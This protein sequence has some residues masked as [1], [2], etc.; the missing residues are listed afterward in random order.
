MELPFVSVIVL[1]FNGAHFLPTCLNALRTQTYPAQRF[2]VIVTDNGSTDES[3]PLLK[4]EYP[5]VRILENGRN[6]GFSRANNAA[7][8][9]AEGEYVILLNNDTA[10]EP[11]W[12]EKMVE[13]AE[14]DPKIGVVSGHLRL[15]YDQ[16][17]LRLETETFT[18][19][20]D[21]RHLG[22][23]VYEVD[24]G[25]FRSVTQ[26]LDGFYWRETQNGLSWRW[27]QGQAR[28]GIP[29]PVGEG[30]C[31]VRF[32]LA[33]NRSDGRTV[34]L[35]IFLRGT[36]M[37]EWNVT[38]GS[39]DFELHLPADARELAMPVEQNTGSIVFR[40]GAG[41]DRGTYVK[42]DEVFY[43]TD[44]GQYKTAEEVFSACGAS[45]LLRREMTDL[46]GLLDEDFFIYYED[47]DLSWRA[48][49][50][51]WKVFYSPEALVRHIHCGTN[52]EWSPFFI[53]LTERNRLAMVFKDGTWSQI[54]RVWGGYYLRLLRM[55]GSVLL[56]WSRRNPNWHQQ[57]SSL[58]L[59]LRIAFKLL[60]WLPAL[61]RKRYLIQRGAVV[62]SE[63]VLDTWSVS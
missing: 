18:P 62:P 10:P 40:N 29:L 13:V 38:A 5:W 46:V 23:M 55:G 36:L 41:R 27:M 14:S 59:H 15:Y 58:K 43:E 63:Q 6:L 54:S 9:V 2:E 1:N 44:E 42:N 53:Y 16:L 4:R 47:T 19:P 49:L 31:T 48:R 26:Y 3:L 57:A 22:L 32:R 30:D 20:N 39:T 11:M 34:P 35:R 28:L 56:A 33:S 24:T 17:E 8:R 37:A 60:V 45:M 50:A 7:V 61:L 51:G 25:T 52:T 12:I 21:P